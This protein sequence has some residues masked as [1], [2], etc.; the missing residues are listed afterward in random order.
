M[1]SRLCKDWCVQP[2]IVTYNIVISGL[3]RHGFVDEAYGLFKMIEKDP[4]DAEELI[5]EIVSKELRILS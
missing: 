1:F 4:L 2:N 3:C 5:Q